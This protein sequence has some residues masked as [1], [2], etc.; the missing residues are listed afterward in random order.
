MKSEDLYAIRW[1]VIRLRYKSDSWLSMDSMAKKKDQVARLQKMQQKK[2]G[3]QTCRRLQESAQEFVFW[4][5]KEKV[6]NRLAEMNN[7]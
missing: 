7:S 3:H 1:T 5:Y 6:D 2:N 4:G